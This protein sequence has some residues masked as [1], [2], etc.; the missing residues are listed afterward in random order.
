MPWTATSVG[1]CLLPVNFSLGRG[2]MSSA[3]GAP[4]YAVFLRIS[5]RG[6]GGQAI[7]AAK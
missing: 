3:F 7:R 1:T 4:G 5:T 2:R 6:L